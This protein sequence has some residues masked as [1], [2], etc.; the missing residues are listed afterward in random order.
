MDLI[1]K[2]RKRDFSVARFT[3]KKISDAV[4]HAFEKT[5][6]GNQKEADIISAKVVDDLNQLCQDRSEAQ[7]AIEFIPDVEAVQDLV[8]AELILGS[9]VK[10]AKEYILYRERRSQMRDSVGSVPKHV[11]QL[12]KKSKKFFKNS[13]AEFVYYRTYA[14]WIDEENRRETWIETVDR[15]VSFMRENLGD[16]LTEEEYKE[17]YQSILHQEAM[18]SMRLL[19][20]A[21]AAARRSN[22]CAYNCSFIAPSAVGD[23]AE[24]LYILMCGSGVGFSVEKERIKRLPVIKKQKKS[25]VLTHTVDD[26]KEGWADA[27]TLGLTTWFAGDDIDFDYSQ[28]RPAGARLITSGGKSSGPEPLRQLLQFSRQ[29]ILG[30]Q[31]DQLSS[32]EVHD[33]ICKIG[34]CVVAGGVRRSAL[35]SLSDLSDVEMRDSKKGQFYVNEPQRCLA[36]NSAIYEERPSATHFM[37]EWLALMKSGSG[38]RGIFNRGATNKTL[39]ERRLREKDGEPIP[40][41]TNPC[42]E[43]ILRSKQFCNLSEVVARTEDTEKTL[44]KKIRVAAILGTY[45]STLTDFPYISKEWKNNCDEER[46]LGVSITGQWDCALARQ[47]E[48][49]ETLQKE[50]TRVNKL[51]A[52][53]FEIP[54]SACITC[55]K[56]SGTLS[57]LVDCSSGMHPRH[58][59]YYIR[60]VRIS[61]T[62]SLFKMLRD[63]GVPYHPEV[64]QAPDSATTFVLEF[65]VKAPRGATFKD[66]ITALEQLDH[67]KTVKKAF[68]DHNPSVTISIGDNEWIKVSDWIYDNWN[69]V[70]GLSFLP[71]T[72]HVYKLA[73]YEEITR[74]HYFELAKRFDYIDFSKIVTYER[75]NDTDIKREFACVAGSCEI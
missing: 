35:I 36:N 13:L 37:E 39:P 3:S 67:W 62:D 52:K 1:Q 59:K 47:P 32:L 19:Q 68:T 75:E 54:M 70:G 48:V 9:Y 64:G 25:K 8:E 72:D 26:S 22:V 16:K 29:I 28:L 45:Q 17:V 10:T 24:I 6:E 5:E 65:P 61:A 41:G 63:Q 31:N 51:Y 44:M 55:V 7:K 49:L 21:G 60:R 14:R 43:I 27:L 71:R 11:K 18:P 38:E 33:I 12:V 69:I 58:A 15:Y 30:K 20:F 66:D 42:G 2:I 74:E 40:W 4:L 23:F 73:P 50:A 34:E 53:K 56:P 57:Q 46:L